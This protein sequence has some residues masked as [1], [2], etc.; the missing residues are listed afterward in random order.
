MAPVYRVPWSRQ[1]AR[2]RRCLLLAWPWR[3]GQERRIGR[4]ACGKLSEAT[5]AAAV[6]VGMVAAS[7][8]GGWRPPERSPFTEA[9]CGGALC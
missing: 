4:E 8:F 5:V 1:A 2:S 7:V 3:G 9:G 6:G